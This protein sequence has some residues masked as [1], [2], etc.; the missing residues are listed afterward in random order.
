MG[1]NFLNW[2]FHMVQPN[3]KMN[4]LGVWM[5]QEVSERKQ[6]TE[7]RTA[8]RGWQA[9]PPGGWEVN[10][11]CWVE[12]VRYLVLK[13]LQF[14]LTAWFTLPPSVILPAPSDVSAAG[15]E[16]NSPEMAL[17]RRILLTSNSELV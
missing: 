1:H 13:S 17:S 9:L 3:N 16:V 14:S 4:G 2:Q 15:V 7:A 11:Q 12:R 5:G 6:A 10:L 8:P